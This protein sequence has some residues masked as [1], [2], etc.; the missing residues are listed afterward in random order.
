MQYLRLYFILDLVSV[1]L[2]LTGQYGGCLMDVRRSLAM[3]DWRHLLGAKGV[4]HVFI[5]G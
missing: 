3:E 5:D 4:G 2:S 1:A